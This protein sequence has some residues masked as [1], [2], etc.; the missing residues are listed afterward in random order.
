M[1]GNF[2]TC[3]LYVCYFCLCRGVFCSC[4][5]RISVQAWMLTTSTSSRHGYLHRQNY[6]QLYDA[7]AFAK[8]TDENQP[9]DNDDDDENEPSRKN[10]LE[11]WALEGAQKIAQLDIQERTQRALLAEMAEDKIY[12][13]NEALERLMDEDTGEI[14]DLDQAR[15]IVQQTRSLQEQYR[16]LVT[17]GPSSMLQAMASLNENRSRSD[18][19]SY[20]K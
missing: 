15:D 6:F 13:L 10:W 7:A 18:G 2:L 19:D 4:L 17:G 9:N 11:D 20:E 16:T 14:L 8:K 12:E 5:Q 3:Y 1:L